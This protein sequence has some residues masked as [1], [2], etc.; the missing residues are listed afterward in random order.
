MSF[1]N[2]INFFLTISFLLI[3][4]VSAKEKKVIKVGYFVAP[5]MIF[6]NEK[7]ELKGPVYDFIKSMEQISDYQFKFERYPNTRVYNELQKGNVQMLPTSAKQLESKHIINND[8][9][10]FIDKPYLIARKDFKLD[11]I[12]NIKQLENYV[13]GIKKDGAICQ[14]L[15]ENKNKLKFEESAGIDSVYSMLPKLLANRVD[16]IHAYSTHVIMYLAKKKNISDK[17]KL[18]EVPGEYAKIYFGFSNKL[19]IKDRVKLNKLIK[20]LLIEKKINLTEQIKNWN[21]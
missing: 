11:K 6:E 10:Y 9:P 15:F 12:T 17:I 7:K 16:F 13:I 19:D 18:V 21:D 2:L 1:G 5:T 4:C 3:G 14:F 20:Y 8:T